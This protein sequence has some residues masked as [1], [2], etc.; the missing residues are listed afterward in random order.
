MGARLRLK[1]TLFITDTI[2]CMK[3]WAEAQLIRGFI[4]G[5]I[6][7]SSNAVIPGVQV[8]ITNTGTNISRDT[9]TNEIG[10]YRFV[11]VEPGNYSVEFRLPGFE[12]RKVPSVTV[13]TA[14]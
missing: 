12:N 7:D 2:F 11:A 1:L 13:S 8:S 9:T 6:T 10:F 5:T 14:A 4:S 3:M